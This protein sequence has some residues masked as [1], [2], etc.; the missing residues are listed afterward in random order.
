VGPLKDAVTR[1]VSLTK[2]KKLRKGP[3]PRLRGGKT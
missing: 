1:W 3:K 2:Q